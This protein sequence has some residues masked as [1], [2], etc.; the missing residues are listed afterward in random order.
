M[1]INA[2]G[3]RMTV[4]IARQ[5]RLAQDIVRTQT[6]I[7]TGRRMAAASDDPVAAARVAVLT[8]AQADGVAWQGNLSL[9]A[10]RASQADTAIA[11]LSSHIVR[12]REAVLAGASG[13]ATA[14]GCTWSLIHRARGAGLSGSSSRAKRT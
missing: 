3:G 9:A 13:T 12:A 4:E 2:T 5:S 6:S 7:S 14:A 1:T 11:A 10:A 8:R